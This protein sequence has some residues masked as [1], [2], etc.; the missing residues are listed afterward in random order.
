MTI[1]VQ[2]GG[3]WVAV[4]PRDMTTEELCLALANIQLD[5]DEFIPKKEIAEGYAAIHEAIRRLG[6]R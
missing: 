4:N 2:R 1:E 6:A 3:R 5:S